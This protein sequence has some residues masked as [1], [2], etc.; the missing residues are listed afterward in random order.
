MTFHVEPV[1]LRDFS[2]ELS[3]ARYDEITRAELYVK[4]WGDLSLHQQGVI[5]AVIGQH[6]RLM[7]QLVDMFDAL[8]TL[9]I[10]NSE[11]LQTI[12]GVYEVMDAQAAAEID[13]S[14]PPT[15]RP[16]NTPI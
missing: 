3:T 10:R 14:L 8:E 2:A 5:G 11:S 12:A 1:A 6:R 13:A 9:A 15:P 4:L 16:L 7:D